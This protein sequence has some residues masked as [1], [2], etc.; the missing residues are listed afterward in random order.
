MDIEGKGIDLMHRRRLALMTAAVSLIVFAA[1]VP[2]Q[3]VDDFADDVLTT[4]NAER[5]ELGVPDLVWSDALARDAAAWAQTLKGGGA[6]RH[7]GISGQGENLW[8]GTRGAYDTL[9]MVDSWLEERG[10]F[11]RGRF[12]NVSST[13]RWPDVGHYTQMIW[14]NTRVIGCAVSSD[15]DFDYLVCRYFP[16]GNWMGEDPLDG[17]EPHLAGRKAP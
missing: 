7:S 14:A 11:K 4:H 1:P 5:A 6:L 15:V 13:G 9:E 17:R 10:M 3:E 12:P 8:M 2:A 16:A